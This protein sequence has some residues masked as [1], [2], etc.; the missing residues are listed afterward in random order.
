VNNITA[1]IQQAID[2]AHQV[3]D[4]MSLIND[5]LGGL[6]TANTQLQQLG[7]KIVDKLNAASD[8]SGISTALNNLNQAIDDIQATPM[9][10]YLFPTL[11]DLIARITT[12]DPQNRLIG[13][14]QTKQAFPLAELN[15]L[16]D[17]PQKTAI[18]NLLADFDPMAN[19][20]TLPLGGLQDRLN[21]LQG[22]RTQLLAFFSTSQSR[23]HQ[24]NGPLSLYRQKDLTLPQLKAMLADTVHTQLSTTLSPAFQIIEKFQALLSSILSEVSNLISK[25]E[26][27]AAS[28]A[29]IGTALEEMRK[30]IHDVVDLLNGLDITFIAKAIDDIFEAVKAQLNAINTQKIGSLLTATFNHLLDALDPNTLLG[31]AD[32]DNQHTTLINL[33]KDRDPKVL[34]TQTV[35]PEFDKIL[36]FLNEFNISDLLNT[37]LQRIEDLKTQLNTELDRT[38]TAYEDMVKIIPSDLQGELGVSVSVTT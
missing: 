12:L 3:R 31:L 4:A 34:V 25:L 11:D 7:D 35:Q 8:F 16:A 10:Q 18:L 20:F 2:D 13:L 32:L 19:E 26:V 5:R 37:F 38:A 36:V 33:L 28:L 6:S 30:G 24:P 29:Q 22:A 17:S 21:D 14:V 9:Q 15:A 1:I 23:Y 27:Q